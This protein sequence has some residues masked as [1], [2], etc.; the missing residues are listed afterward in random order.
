MWKLL[1]TGF[2]SKDNHA[3]FLKLPLEMKPE[4]DGDSVKN[5]DE[6]CSIPDSILPL[7]SLARKIK[8]PMICSLVLQNCNED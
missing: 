8:E 3:L 4:D 2:A 6:E 1:H 5:M 7:V